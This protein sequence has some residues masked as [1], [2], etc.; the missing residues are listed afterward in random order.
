MPGSFCL[1]CLL[2]LCAPGMRTLRAWDVPVDLHRR[3]DG[4]DPLAAL[5]PHPNDHIAGIT[6]CKSAGSNLS[7]RAGGC[8]HGSVQAVELAALVIL[9]ALCAIVNV[10]VVAGY[11]NLL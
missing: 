10:E 6:L 4:A 11:G 3:F 2:H 7:R 8:L 9:H 5:V 1:C